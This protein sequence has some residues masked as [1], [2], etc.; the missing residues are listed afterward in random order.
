MSSFALP[1]AMS[2]Q[3]TRSLAVAALLGATMLASPLSAARAA[4]A[5]TAPFQQAQAVA[6]PTPPAAAAPTAA[7]TPT[8]ATAPTATAATA[9]ETKAET[10]EQRIT[11]LHTAL[12]ITPNEES[13]WNGV[14]KAMRDNAAAIQKLAADKNAQDSQGMTA[15]D[16][17]KTYEK[18]ARAHVAG[19]KHLT[20]SFEKL[21]NAMPAPQKKVADDVFQNFG[22]HEGAASHS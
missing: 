17:L 3:V 19:L 6:P 7:T 5:T 21:Y 16:D 20:V 9:V 10:V 11:S 12:Q 4:P 15:L 8:A 13:N 22:H 1:I 2:A 14:A 18:F